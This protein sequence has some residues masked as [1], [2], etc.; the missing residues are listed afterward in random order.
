MLSEVYETILG[1]V[2][3][4]AMDKLKILLQKSITK[5]IIPESD[6][7]PY[8]ETISFKFGQLLEGI[9]HLASS[10]GKENQQ[11][12]GTDL[13]MAILEGLQLN[14]DEAECFLLFQL[15]KLGRFRK[16]ESEFLTEL[17]GLWKT[18]PDYELADQDF[19]RALK[20]L[21]REK[22]I[23]YRKGSIQVNTSFILRYRI[24]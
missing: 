15:R 1:K 8:I 17:K 14:V 16:R 4:T 23:L 18:Y 24:S 9:E 3:I 19:S 22:L 5:A 2:D 13:L 12:L 7:K 10:K 21:M 11:A 6:P 20:S